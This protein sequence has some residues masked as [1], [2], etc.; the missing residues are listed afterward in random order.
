MCRSCNR[1]RDES[2]FGHESICNDCR[3][4]TAESNY[5]VQLNTNLVEFRQYFNHESSQGSQL[6]LHQRTILVAL[7]KLGFDTEQVAHMADCDAR[8]V[9]M[10]LNRWNLNHNFE[11]ERRTG[12]HRITSEEEDEYIVQF[13]RQNPDNTPRSIRNQLNLD[14]SNKLV[15]RRLDDASLFGRISRTE[16]PFTETNLRKRRA[17]ATTHA[18]WSKSKWMRVVFADETY[19]CVGG[20]GQTWVQRPPGTEWKP[21]HMHQTHT[22][23]AAK[24]GLFGCFSYKGPGEFLI[25]AWDMNDVYY[26]GV[27]EDLVQPY[28][29]GMWPVSHAYY[30]HD[31]ASYHTSKFSQSWFEGK[32]IEPIKLPPHSPDLNPTENLWNNLKRRI[33][34]FHPTNVHEVIELIRQEWPK[35][36]PSY[37]HHLVESMPERMQAVLQAEGHMTRY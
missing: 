34:G 31:N 4:S 22:Q 32:D 25:Y 21:E 33:D 36:D 10:W 3:H 14:V 9:D 26:Y 7:R 5:H 37:C 20:T 8:T 30:L 23:F 13:A 35:T 1:K 19:I 29:R 17:F 27:L 11:P 2:A 16:Y 18:D 15:R 28:L 6:T 12:A 24:I